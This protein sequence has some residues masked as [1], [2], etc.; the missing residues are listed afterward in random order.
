MYAQF[1]AGNK[2]EGD[3]AIE[4]SERSRHQRESECARD[5]APLG[6]ET[7]G[8]LSYRRWWRWTL[9]RKAQVLAL[10]LVLALH[11]LFALMLW[12]A[13]R[14]PPADN[15]QM[16]IVRLLTDTPTLRTAPPPPPKLAPVPQAAAPRVRPGPHEKVRPDAAVKRDHVA[17]PVPTPA[18]P[19]ATGLFAADGS[20]KLPPMQTNYAPPPKRE[21]KPADDR[22]I[23]QHPDYMHYKP[24]RFNKYFPPPNETAGGAVGRHIGNVI[25]AIAKSICDPAKRGTAFNPLCDTTPP[26]SPMNADERLNLPPPSLAG[27]THPA[28]Q[29]PLSTCIAEYADGKPLSY[30]CPINTPD[31]AFQAE[32]RICIDLFRAGKRLKTWCPADTPKRA[33]A[34]SSMPASSSTVGSH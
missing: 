6:S 4:R 9:P 31:L 26:P 22:Q 16:L 34:E 19:A 12:S 21:A 28:R 17:A 29:L 23:M 25:Q 32:V 14:L 10:A 11:I 1:C 15:D 27:D 24:T 13:T 20:I 30:G 3:H 5:L 18:I 33:A 7:Y 8:P 2:L